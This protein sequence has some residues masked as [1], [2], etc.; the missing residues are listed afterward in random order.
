MWEECGARVVIR[1]LVAMYSVP[2][3]N[4]IHM[5]F[6]ADW[7]GAE[8]L[9]HPGAETLDTKLASPDEVPWDR[10]AFPSGR[11]ALQHA[12]SPSV[13]PTLLNYANNGWPEG[14]RTSDDDGASEKLAV[15]PTDCRAIFEELK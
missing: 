10:L 9:F 14:W 12:L 1:G 2:A 13:L 3:V 8:E 15:L 11:L 4:Q 7:D 5:W 6:A